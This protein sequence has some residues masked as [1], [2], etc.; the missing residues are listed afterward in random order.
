MFLYTC[1]VYPCIISNA[2]FFI[3]L[4]GFH[5]CTWLCYINSEKLLSQVCR[6]IVPYSFSALP[7]KA[8]EPIQSFREDKVGL[9]ILGGVGKE[10]GREG[11]EP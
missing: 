10:T 11:M 2:D 5:L 7:I 6:N 9:P 4:S 1:K 8:N 3:S